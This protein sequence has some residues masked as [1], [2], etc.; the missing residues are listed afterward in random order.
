MSALADMALATT[1][2]AGPMGATPGKPVGMVCFGFARRTDKGIVAHA[3]TQVF[4]GDRAQVREQAVQYVLE[5]A[6]HEVVPHL[7][8]PQPSVERTGQLD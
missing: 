1:G 5:Q 7:A 3:S 6:K 2:I 4:K 8:P